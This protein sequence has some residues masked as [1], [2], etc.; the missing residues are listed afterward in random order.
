MANWTDPQPVVV[1]D[2]VRETVGGHLLV[3]EALVR[4]GVTT[5]A[6]ARAFLDPNHY[7]PASAVELPDID[8]AADRIWR[9]LVTG[10][11]LA[12]FGDF[13]VDG[14]TATALLVEALRE[15]SA[16][17]KTQDIAQIHYRVPQ[18]DQGHGINL[19]ALDELLDQ[20]TSL[21]ITCDT[22]VDAFTAIERAA[23]RGC[24]AVV[25]DHH[26]LPNNLPPATAVVNPKR[27]AV[28]HP[29]R[30]LPGVGVAYKLVEH[31]YLRAGLDSDLQTLLDL[32]ALGIVA[33]VATQVADVRY[34]LQRGLETLRTTQRVGLRALLY[35]AELRPDGLTEGHIGYQIAPRLNALGRM[36]D[37]CQGVEMLLTQDLARARI[38]AAEM[39]GLNHQRRLVTSQVTQAA[40]TQI[41]RDSSLLD[42]RVL[43]IAGYS[44]H[45]GVLGLV[46]GRLA[47]Q[48]D[49]PAV[50][51]SITPE[52]VARGSARS[53]PGCDIHAALMGAANLLIRFGGHPRA[54]GLTLDSSNLGSFR[55]ALS[56]SAAVIWDPVAASPG[57]QIDSYLPL[58]QLSLDLVEELERLAPFGP[59][60][61]PVQLA[62]NDLQIVEDA[63]VGRDGEHRRLVVADERG[64]QQT[65]LW[66][67]SASQ[68]LP[69][70]RFDLAYALRARDY[71][72]EMQLQVEWVD[73]RPRQSAASI[74]SGLTRA[75]IDWRDE[76]DVRKALAR[77]PETGSV[78]WAEGEAPRVTGE[79]WGTDR[80]GLTPSPVLVIWTAPPGPDELTQAVQAVDP[81]QVYLFAFEPATAQLRI[82][83]EYLAGM[84][85]HDMRTRG[86]RVDIRRLAAA[87]GHRE[88]TVRAG[89]EWLVARGQLHVVEADEDT[90]ILQTGGE[91]SSDSQKI[92]SRL[93]HLLHETAAYRRHFRI[94]P[95]K[96]LGISV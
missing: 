90:L 40:L 38:L 63:V 23:A 7:T 33:D 74:S 64:T 2:A 54:A 18:R 76:V 73:A 5:P 6:A 66:W 21:L 29:L 85:K 51:L 47:E 30:E 43:V 91:P 69:E 88:V 42:D 39:D 11:R 15:L 19:L 71:R 36:G 28:D 12:V 62:T 25:T 58:D 81:D 83:I 65:V 68:S 77:L 60:N 59:G 46:A 70:G 24:E 45:A 67:Q 41:E 57:L 13:D 72:G 20:G 84:I 79:M 37:A 16:I 10:E 22:G 61:P 89:L 78:V 3:A 14:L 35:Q 75:V 96:T 82:L 9:G 92:Q 52:G 48:F 95:A 27:L 1:S 94:A 53:V 8:R 86:G 55:K 44:W 56:R 49:R 17:V 4:R 50:V 34:L 80:L 87:L 93:R 31:L 32:V 26:D